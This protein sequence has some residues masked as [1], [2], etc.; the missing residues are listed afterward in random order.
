MR[1]MGVAIGSIQ[2]SFRIPLSL[3]GTSRRTEEHVDQRFFLDGKLN[4]L[5]NVLSEVGIDADEQ[6]LLRPIG[7]FRSPP[8]IKLPDFLD[9]DYSKIYHTITTKLGWTSPEKNAEHTDCRVDPV[10]Q[11]IRYRKFPDITPEVLHFSKLV[12]CGQMTRSEALT[13]IEKAKK[14]GG[15]PHELKLFFDKLGIT[16]KEFE[17]VLASPM[18]HLKYLKKRSAVI[19][20]IKALKQFILPY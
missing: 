11:Y 5:E 7:I 13:Q 2:L 8:A 16:E 9:W 17:E 1:G 3:S 4:F 20:R 14:R 6:F 18:R 15:R 12:T 10:V 19:R